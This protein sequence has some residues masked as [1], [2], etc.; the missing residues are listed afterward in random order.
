[1]QAWF[2]T[3]GAERDERQGG[4]IAIGKYILQLLWKDINFQVH[5]NEL[6]EIW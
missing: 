4:C 5:K 3:L 1:M 6:V 2:G